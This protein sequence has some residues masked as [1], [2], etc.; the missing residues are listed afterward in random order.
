VRTLLTLMMLAGV[1]SAQKV[2]TQELLR[3]ARMRAPGLEQALRDTFDADKLAKGKA[4]AGEMGDFVWAVTAEK[5]P[6]LQ[7]NHEAP[8]AAFKAGSLWVIQGRLN[9]GTSYKYTWLVDGKPVGGANNLAAFGPD[10]YPQ[11]GAPQGKLTGPIEVPSTIY[12]GVKA[13]V[14]FYVPAQW[15]GVTPLALQVWGDGQQFTGPRPGP[16]RIL[17]TLDNLTAQKRIPLMVSIFI[18][19]G[20]GPDRNERSIEYDTVND[21]YLH[22]LFDEIFPVVAKSV[23]MRSDG[24]SRAIQGLSS[25]GIMAFNAGFDKPEVFSRVLSWIGSYTALRRSTEHPEGGGEYPTMVRRETKRNIRVWLE[26]GSEDL[27]NTAGNW[28]AANIGMANA[29]KFK[30]YDYHFSFGVGEH[31][32]GQ[33]AAELPE[34]LTWL[35]RD[36][37]PAKTSQEFVQDPAEKDQPVWRVVQ[38]NRQ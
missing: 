6:A 19:A 9:T 2:S 13:N 11:P 7:I 4:A 8:M 38:L 15:D 10:S 3:M 36:Y 26:D 29:L 14:W 32:N 22:R 30:G 20:A 33:G 1:C 28:P 23:K 25:G 35:W 31:N 21:A 37:D 16:W 5:G 17:E 12:V 27:D 24:Y 34:S 18:Q